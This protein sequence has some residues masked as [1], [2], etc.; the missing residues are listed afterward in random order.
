MNAR[1]AE[2]IINKLMLCID[3]SA[4]IGNCEDLSQEEVE[5]FTIQSE[6]FINKIQTMMSSELDRFTE[7]QLRGVGEHNA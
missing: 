1:V 6:G 4:T 2:N 5:R 7:L 3:D